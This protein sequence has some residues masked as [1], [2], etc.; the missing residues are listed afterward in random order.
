[1][2]N[3]SLRLSFSPVALCG[4]GVAVLAVT[5]LC[6]IAVVMSYA[7]VTMEFSQSA[8]NE[9][10]TVAVLESQYLA[11]LERLTS[12][13]YVAEGYALPAQQAFVPAKSVTARR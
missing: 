9:K 5:Y 11:A 1:M 7:T 13:D 12:T 6:L 8:K 2:H 3:F 10:A 4:T